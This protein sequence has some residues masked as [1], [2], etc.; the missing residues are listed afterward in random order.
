MALIVNVL[1]AGGTLTL[2]LVNDKRFNIGLF[3][4][5]GGTMTLCLV[6]DNRFNI[7]L[8][9]IAGGTMTLRLGNADASCTVV[10]VATSTTLTPPSIVRPFA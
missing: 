4:V 9:M 5:A 10:L 6:N 2:C 1:V 8:F 7:G 3:M